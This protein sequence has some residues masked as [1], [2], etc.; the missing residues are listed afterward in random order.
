MFRSGLHRGPMLAAAACAA[1]SWFLAPVPEARASIVLT[2]FTPYRTSFEV[3]EFV[4]GPG[5][6]CSVSSGP[7][8]RSL[9]FSV[10]GSADM[11]DLLI[12]VFAQSLANFP[13]EGSFTGVRLSSLL[14]TDRPSTGGGLAHLFA[15]GT[16]ASR[17]SVSCTAGVCR[18]TSTQ[19][20]QVVRPAVSLPYRDFSVRIDGEHNGPGNVDLWLLVTRMSTVTGPGPVEGPGSG[21]PGLPGGPGLI[22]QPEVIPLPA[23]VWLFAG[24]LV[25]LLAGARRG[26]P[27]SGA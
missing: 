22:G 16:D 9:A 24:G 23:A 21:G 15:T 14:L 11:T 8:T 4:C 12:E 3:R 5:G 13:L 18:T 1:L 2:P 10:D 27:G 25:V 17:D 6:V 7:F 26:R 20:E 19:Y